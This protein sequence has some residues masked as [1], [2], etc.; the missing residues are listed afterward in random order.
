MKDLGKEFMKLEYQ[1]YSE[2]SELH[3]KAVDATIR[4][5]FILIAGF[6]SVLAY[7]YKDN[8]EA[9]IICKINILLLGILAILFVIGL[10]TLFKIIEHRILL[11]SYIRS[12]NG[13]RRWFIDNSEVSEDYFIY[14]ADKTQPAYFKRFRHFYWE[15]LGIAFINSF[16][17]IILL[18]NALPNTKFFYLI[19]VIV[20]ITFFQMFFYKK[21]S[22][23]KEK[24][25]LN[26]NKI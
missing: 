25:E 21:R 4:L 24:Q 6:M 26:D 22:Q 23:N 9:F 14:K 19:I 8:L 10:I 16:F 20:L 15:I 3:Y 18:Y 7:V 5:Y 11:L 1:F 17:G 12:L 13:V 2:K